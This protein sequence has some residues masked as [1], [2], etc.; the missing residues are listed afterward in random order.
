MQSQQKA[1]IYR[2]SPW[3]K[4]K[5]ENGQAPQDR[6]REKTAYCISFPLRKIEV[7]IL[8]LPSDHGFFNVFF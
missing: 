4:G 7:L 2:S 5:V 6:Q 8:I 3:Q 1:F